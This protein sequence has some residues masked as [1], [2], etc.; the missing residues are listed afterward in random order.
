VAGACCIPHPEKCSGG[1]DSYFIQPD[2]TGVGVADGVGEWECRFKCNPRAFADELMNGCMAALAPALS[3]GDLDPRDVALRALGHAYSGARSM[4]SATALVAALHQASGLLGVANLGDATLMHLRPSGAAGA[5]LEC[6]GRTREQQH[7]FNCPYQLAR[8]P[9]EEEIPALLREGKHALVRALRQCKSLRLDVPEDADRYL[10]QMQAGDLLVL[11][12]DGVFDNL[13]DE[14]VLQLAARAVSP[15]EARE[16]STAPGRLAEAIAQAALHRSMDCTTCSPFGLRA[17][18][19]GLRH[20]GGKMDD[21]TCV[22]AWLL[23]C[24][25]QGAAGVPEV[26]PS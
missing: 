7:S 9:T 14:D 23:P 24:G 4:G 8:L 22:C 21:I 16:T 26:E 17:M 12:T 19:A 3:N 25:L 2:G 1:A 10:L 13:H 15:W 11:G 6:V 20:A 5:A 18:E